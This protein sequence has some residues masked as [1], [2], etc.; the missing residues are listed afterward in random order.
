M[1]ATLYQAHR[2]RFA[3]TYR[4][5]GTDAAVWQA[6]ANGVTEKLTCA[7]VA[8]FAYAGE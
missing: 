6:L 4:T 5:L 3:Y 1:N 7:F 8:H 2:A